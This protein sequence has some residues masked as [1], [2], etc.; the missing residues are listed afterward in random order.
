MVAKSVNT[1]AAKKKPRGK[2]F[3]GKDDPR[4]SNNGQ[5][6]AAAVMFASEIRQIIV[7]LGEESVSNSKGER[8]KR[9]EVAVLGMYDR[10][11]QG[12]V[13]AFNTLVERVEGKV[14]APVELSGRDGG[15]LEI[16]LR[17]VI[18]ETNAND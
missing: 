12:D 4:R 17:E 16:V 11:M 5:R 3:T 8:R 7:A 6:S 15:P 13:S 14:V 1:N 10:A 18:K 9:I 2:A